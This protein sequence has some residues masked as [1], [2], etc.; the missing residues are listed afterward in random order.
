MQWL[1]DKPNPKVQNWNVTE[2]RID[3]SKRH[4]DKATVANFWK[5][6]EG[7]I[8]QNKPQIQI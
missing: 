1:T 8:G 2:L 3:R 5:A 7:W 6:L 4:I